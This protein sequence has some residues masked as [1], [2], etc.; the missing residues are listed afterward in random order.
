MADA[1]ERGHESVAQ[2]PSDK[3]DQAFFLDLAAKGKDAWNAWRRDPTN[4]D[5][6]VTF[7]GVDFSEAPKDQIDFSGFAFGDHVD[8]SNCKW[9]GVRL[10]EAV[11]VVGG[12]N[13]SAFQPGR[14]FFSGAAFGLGT[15]FN[16]GCFGDWAVFYGATFEQGVDFRDAVVGDSAMFNDANFSVFAD[17]SGTTFGAGASFCGAGF[18]LVIKFD[19]AHFKGWISFSAE[20]QEEWNKNVNLRMGAEA[21]MELKQRHEALWKRYDSRPDRLPSI[22]FGGAL[23][24]GGADFS[25]RSFE[26]ATDFTG[27]RFYSPPIF[28]NV[29]SAD[30]IDFTGVHVG[31]A[32]KGR[33]IDLTTDSRIPLRLRALRKV[34]EATKNHDLERDLYIEE[35]KAERGVYWSQCLQ[36]LT[37][38][39]KVEKPLVVARLLSH[40]LWI[41]VMF[42][43]WA[44]AN[45]GR[46][47]VLPVAWL[48]LSVWVFQCGYASTLVPLKQKAGPANASQ[49]ERAGRTMAFG[50]AV[51][52]VGPLTID[53]ETKKFLFCAGDV[54]NKCLPIPP[55][56]FQLLVIAQNLLSIALVF[57][58]GLALRNYFKIK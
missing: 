56:D 3:Y 57:F 44:L 13:P 36:D 23:F 51:P 39:P 33:F 55:E 1:I 11:Q 42:F 22:S 49:Y 12:F 24:D 47:F 31:F 8:F 40:G 17:F 6:R 5:M 54:P 53:A 19:Q 37:K 41:A 7:A 14:A 18:W 25:G 28:D 38:A 27:A 20:T 35:R 45:Y 21:G 30:R 9:R 29:T 43:Y 26:H 15:N 10:E 50:N 58:T 16:G 52:F 48:I 32:P 46:S 2:N 34:V 4:K